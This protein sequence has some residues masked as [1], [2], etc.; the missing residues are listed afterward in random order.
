MNRELLGALKLE[1]YNYLVKKHNEKAFT[2]VKGNLEKALKILSTAPLLEDSI[3]SID[4]ALQLADTEGLIAE[5]I[6]IKR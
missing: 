2:P 6:I 3:I 4:E 1:G 5:I